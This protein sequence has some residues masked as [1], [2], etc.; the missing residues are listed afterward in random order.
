[1]SCE[2]EHKDGGQKA[3][4]CG[5]L[6]SWGGVRG[7]FKLFFTPQTAIIWQSLPHPSDSLFGPQIRLPLEHGPVEEG[8]GRICNPTDSGDRGTQ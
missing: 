2:A 3:E 4:H 7:F 5:F 8:H 6:H 1:M